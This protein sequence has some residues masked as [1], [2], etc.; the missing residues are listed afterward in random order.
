[1]DRGIGALY[2]VIGRPQPNDTI[3]ERWLQ[4]IVKRQMDDPN[5]SMAE[6]TKFSGGCR[7]FVT[8]FSPERNETTLFRSYQCRDVIDTK[9]AIWQAGRA[10]CSHPLFFGPIDIDFPPPPT[11]YI[12]IGGPTNPTVLAITEVQRVWGNTTQFCLVSIGTGRQSNVRILN[13]PPPSR[14]LKMGRQKR[15]G[16]PRL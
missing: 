10:T 2:T 7:T 9:C 12:G 3:L 4:D 13:G 15:T 14:I 6:P 11:W 5:A 1:M 8:S 16:P